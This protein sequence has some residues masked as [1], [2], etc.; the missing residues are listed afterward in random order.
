MSLEITGHS[1]SAMKSV[2]KFHLSSQIYR[3][4]GWIKE[5]LPRIHPN[6]FLDCSAPL[7]MHNNLCIL[8]ESFGAQLQCLETIGLV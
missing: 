8:S 6:E 2:N 1:P 7:M 5:N 3:V 4:K